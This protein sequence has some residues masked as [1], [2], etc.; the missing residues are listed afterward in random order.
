MRSDWPV[1]LAGG[2]CILLS[3]MP[4]EGDHS[5]AFIFIT[6][7]GFILVLFVRFALMARENLAPW[8]ETD[9]TYVVYGQRKHGD[10][11]PTPNPHSS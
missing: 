2:L 10:F 11:G 3:P 9:H 1:Q 4:T 5:K 8:D 6:V 7:V